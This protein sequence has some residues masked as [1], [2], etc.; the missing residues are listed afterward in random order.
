M[1]ESLYSRREPRNETLVEQYP[2]PES[3]KVIIDT[4]MKPDELSHIISKRGGVTS[5][6]HSGRDLTNVS[7]RPW[8]NPGICTGI[9]SAVAHIGKQGLGQVFLSTCHFVVVNKASLTLWPFLSQKSSYSSM[10]SMVVQ[11][12]LYNSAPKRL[13]IERNAEKAHCYPDPKQSNS[14]QQ[15]ARPLGGVRDVLNILV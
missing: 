2:I 4:Y 11:R 9:V 7:P 14:R 10:H 13:R 12:V 8:W 1:A 5:R 3:R 6:H 15:W